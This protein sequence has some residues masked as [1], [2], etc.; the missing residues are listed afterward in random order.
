MAGGSGVDSLTGAE[1][2][3]TFVITEN[4][5][6]AVGTFLGDVITDFQDGANN[7][8]DILQFS[9][10]ALNRLATLAG[11]T[12]GSLVSGVISNA[13]GYTGAAGTQG[14]NFLVTGTNTV[15]ANQVYAQFLYSTESGALSFDVDGT[16][17]KAAINVAMIG[18]SKSLDALDFAFVA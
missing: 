6:T 18:Q 16:G 17:S 10:T 12:A 1:G 8:Q 11:Q 2:N 14:A 15:A 13:M 9:V 3:D 5:A 4:M 7:M